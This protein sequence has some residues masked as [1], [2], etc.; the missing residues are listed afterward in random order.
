M[1]ARNRLSTNQGM[2][3][4]TRNRVRVFEQ[5]PGPGLR[6]Y[7]KRFL[8]V[9]FP[10]L[11]RDEHLP[12][13]RP[14]AAFSFRGGCR[15]DGSQWAPPAA[16]T[17]LRETL[18]AHEHCHGHVVLLATFTPVGATAFLRPSLEEFAYRHENL[19]YHFPPRPPIANRLRQ[20]PPRR[21]NRRVGPTRKRRRPQARPPYSCGG[22]CASRAGEL[23]NRPTDE[24]PITALLF[25]EA[26]DL[27]EAVQIAESHPAL[28]YGANVEVRPWAP[29]V[30]AASAAKT[31]T[32][33]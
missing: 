21:G 28:R 11:Y 10:S 8:V 27:N 22:K 3:A 18:R 24:W 19:R 6:S 25:L 1:I 4:N 2:Q 13:T 33:P 12:D 26:H 15:I 23:Q 29:P 7:I 31:P 20:K 30:P 9:E 32:T 16:F 14:V 17:G 5:L